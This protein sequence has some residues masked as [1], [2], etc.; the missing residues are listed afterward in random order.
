MNKREIGS[1]YE[2]K[3]VEYLEKHGYSIVGQNY[4]CRYGEID[5]IAKKD[6]VLVFVEVKYRKSSKAGLGESV[7]DRK[8]QLHIVKTAQNYMIEKYKTDE[9]SCRFDVI[10]I[11][12]TMFHHIENAFDGY[13]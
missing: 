8:K 4:F 11:N 10:A 6:D 5:I 2:Q 7:V 9:L 3:A 13:Y 12:G 1:A